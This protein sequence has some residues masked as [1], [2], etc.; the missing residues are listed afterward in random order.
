[1]NGVNGTLSG[2]LAVTGNTTLSGNNTINNTVVGTAVQSAADDATAGRLLKVG[3]FG[4]GSTAVSFSGSF[5]SLSATGT[6]FTA[7]AGQTNAPTPTALFTVLHIEGGATGGTVD[8]QLAFSGPGGDGATYKRDRTAGGSWSPWRR[9]L[10]DNGSS[11]IT[12]G[13]NTDG[14]Y[15]RYPDGTQVCWHT[16]TPSAA[17]GTVWT[18][19]ISFSSIPNVQGNGIAVAGQI[20][21]AQVASTPS[22]TSVT[23][24]V[25]D[26]TGARTTNNA[27]LMATGRWF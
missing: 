6:Y 17:A 10:Q 24:N 7:G 5:D 12:R 11:G 13:S 1:L 25:V 21:V 3:A 22:T 26:Q 16:L 2:T 9:F 14:E 19:P 23:F 18:F 4:L 20:R 15:T 8:V 27:M